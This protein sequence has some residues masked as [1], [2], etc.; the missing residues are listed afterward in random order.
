MAVASLTFPLSYIH[1]SMFTLFPLFPPFNALC[2]CITPPLCPFYSI[3][4]L[5]HN[6]CFMYLVIVFTLLKI[7]AGQVHVN[8]KIL[9]NPFVHKPHCL[10]SSVQIAVYSALQQ[11]DHTAAFSRKRTGM[12]VHCRHFRKLLK[13]KYSIMVRPLQSA[14]LGSNHNSITHKHITI[15]IVIYAL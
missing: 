9:D 8:R 15:W 7:M 1:V 5:H 12:T 13:C 6:L 2:I 10:V 3:H 4:S 14:C 11:G